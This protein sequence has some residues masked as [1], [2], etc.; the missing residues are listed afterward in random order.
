MYEKSFRIAELIEKRLTE[1]LTEREE[2]ELQQWSTAAAEN[3][4]LLQRLQNEAWVLK[5]LKTFASCRQYSPAQVLDVA[6]GARVN[7]LVSYRWVAASVVILLG[8][9]IYFYRVFNQPPPAA[10]AD[11]QKGIPPPATNKAMITLA[12]G[13]RLYLDGEHNGKLAQLGNVRLVKLANGQIAYQAE[14]GQVMKELRCNTLTNPQGSKVIDMQLSDGTHV[15][16][17]AGS[18]ITYPVIFAE[19]ERKVTLRGEGYFEVAKNSAK[20][21]IVTTNETQTEVLGTH[22]NINAHE[23]EQN[24]KVTLLEGSVKVSLLDPR[25]GAAK[26]SPVKKSIQ[27]Q[28]G[29]QALVG[30]STFKIINPDMQQVMA[31]KSGRFYFDSDRLDNIL[32][33]VARWYDVDIVYED[34]A[35]RDIDFTG[36]IARKENVSE[37]LKILEITGAV[38][39]NITGR[40]VIVKK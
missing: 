30:P 23:D 20:K 17:N 29:Q 6:K 24:T 33:E 3:Q 18:A 39:F 9:A 7:K 4:E 28:P 10:V 21:F 31:W 8:V 15:W 27:L 14:G 13:S 5:E 22:F 25:N 26:P 35:A 36:G 38:H 40:K 32:K 12:D 37:M 34:T 16:L 1:T 19:N 2:R 11:A